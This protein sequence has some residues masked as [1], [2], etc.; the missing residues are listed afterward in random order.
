VRAA[1]EPERLLG[2]VRRVLAG[3]DSD[4]AMRE[5]RTLEDRMQ[6]SVAEPR[7]RAVLL[8]VFGLVALLLAVLGVY[9]VMAHMVGRRQRE[10]AIRMA[11]GGRPRDILR[12]VAVEAGVLTL[13]GLAVGAT[14]SIALG[15]LIGGL[16]FGVAA[17]DPI[18]YT[19][20]AAVLFIG[21]A[22]ACYLPARRAMRVEPMAAMRGE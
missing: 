4:L 22:L 11:V 21:A 15:R 20:A 12:L 16:L 8:I 5:V 3:S 2:P 17:L 6:R 1:G 13:I 7:Y 18:I 9:G 10:I 19:A 14:A